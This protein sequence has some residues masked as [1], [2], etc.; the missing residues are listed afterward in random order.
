M[1]LRQEMVKGVCEWP[2]FGERWLG[3]TAQGSWEWDSFV[4][5][6]VLALIVLGKDDLPLLTYPSLSAQ[7]NKC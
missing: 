7:S 4:V 2:N 5:S 3:H 6:C 1:L